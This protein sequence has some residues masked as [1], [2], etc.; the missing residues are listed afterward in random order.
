MPLYKGIKMN[1][2]RQG[3]QLKRPKFNEG[4][5]LRENH[6]RLILGLKG[7]VPMNMGR[8]HNDHEKRDGKN[9]KSPVTKEV[10]NGEFKGK[11]ERKK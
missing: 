11:E 4:L 5:S 8:T 7:T 9:K 1:S 10:R 3:L 2:K 6:L